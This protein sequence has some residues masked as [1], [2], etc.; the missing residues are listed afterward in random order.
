MRARWHS[1][2]RSS[3]APTVVPGGTS[4]SFVPQAEAEVIHSRPQFDGQVFF[5]W[6][7]GGGG[8]KCRF[9]YLIFSKQSLK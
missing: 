6:F 1:P 8:K 7:G 5:F 9:I 3:D 2:P 4:R